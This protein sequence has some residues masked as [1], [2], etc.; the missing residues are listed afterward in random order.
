MMNEQ[1]AVDLLEALK[2][3][4][5]PVWVG[6]GWGVDAL[7][8]RQTRP[9]NDIDVYVENSNADAFVQVLA[10]RGYSQVETEYTTGAHTV[11]PLKT[12]PAPYGPGPS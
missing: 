12:L 5:I 3:R 11:W 8:G 10:S 1:D 4:G 9:H 7:V 2:N 6:G